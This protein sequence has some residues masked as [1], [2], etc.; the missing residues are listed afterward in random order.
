MFIQTNMQTKTN[1]IAIN[2]HLNT[3]KIMILNYK[4]KELGKIQIMRKDLKVKNKK[5]RN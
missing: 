5:I 4:R 2:K 3:N 1:N